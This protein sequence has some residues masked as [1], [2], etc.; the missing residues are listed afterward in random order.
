MPQFVSNQVYKVELTD[1]IGDS[2]FAAG[3]ISGPIRG[4]GTDNECFFRL[5]S[6]FVNWLENSKVAG[7]IETAI[8]VAAVVAVFVAICV[9]TDGAAALGTEEVMA[10]VETLVEEQV[11]EEVAAE[12]AVDE[13]GG[14]VETSIDKASGA[15]D[16]T[17]MKDAFAEQN[18]NVQNLFNFP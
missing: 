11:V 13:A 9:L 4:A 10:A 6:G 7:Y 8:E 15:Q 17:Y 1:K 16:L 2:G 5:E 18:T 12:S 3:L 14:T